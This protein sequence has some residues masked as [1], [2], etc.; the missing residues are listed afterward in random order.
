MPTGD[1]KWAKWARPGGSPRTAESVPGERAESPTSDERQITSSC[2]ICK[3]AGMLRKPTGRPGHSEAVPCA[4]KLGEMQQTIWQRARKASGLPDNEAD[5]TFDNFHQDKQPIGHSA[6]REFADFPERQWLVLRGD[7]GTGKT[8]LLVAAANLL[9]V[10]RRPLYFVVPDL[11]DYL[12]AGIKEGDTENGDTIARTRNVCTCDVLLLDDYGTENA[13]PFA[14]E[15]LYEIIDYR[16]RNRLPL[17]LTTNL[18]DSQMPARIAS[19]LND[20]ARV[21]SV[22]M[23]P[24]DYRRSDARADELAALLDELDQLPRLSSQAAD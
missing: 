15:K 23:R 1:Y 6:A 12:R 8:H 18:P 19:R 7:P 13:T 17:A 9:L 16:Y 22:T 5:C 10:K 24:G 3:G 2:P 11:L 20:V 21:R 4:C 14:D